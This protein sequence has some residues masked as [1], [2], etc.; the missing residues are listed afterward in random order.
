MGR[1]AFSIDAEGHILDE[2]LQAVLVGLHRVCPS[3]IFLGSYPS[4]SGERVRPQ[5]GTA[6][7]DFISARSWVAGLL[8]REVPIFD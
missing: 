7:S 5:P 1:Y 4:A 3:V 2:R 8:G 6:D